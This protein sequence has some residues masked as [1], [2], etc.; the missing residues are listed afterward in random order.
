VCTGLRFLGAGRRGFGRIFGEWP[1]STRERR[2]GGFS[3]CH[4]QSLLFPWLESGAS[5]KSRETDSQPVGFSR[6][7]SRFRAVR[8]MAN[9]SRLSGL[10]PGS[11][12]AQRFRERAYSIGVPLDSCFRKIRFRW[13]GINTF[14]RFSR[15]A[16]YSEN[17]MPATSKNQSNEA[18]YHSTEEWS[19]CAG[20]IALAQH[21]S[22]QWRHVIQPVRRDHIR[23]AL[24]EAN[25]TRHLC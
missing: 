8:R 16:F 2:G 17:L 14:S 21:Y 23:H 5:R 24:I 4:S 7:E 1:L 9:L 25:I 3:G 12:K 10:S 6:M 13:C 20:V 22:L 18:I 19:A 15:H 11:W